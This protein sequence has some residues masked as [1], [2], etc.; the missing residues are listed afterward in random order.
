MRS[1]PAGRARHP[2]DKV[3]KDNWGEA[4]DQMKRGVREQEENLSGDRQEVIMGD[5][6]GGRRK[7]KALHLLLTRT[8]KESGILQAPC[9]AESQL[10]KSSLQ[11]T[12]STALASLS[13]QS[14]LKYADYF[15]C[16]WSTESR[17]YHWLF[18]MAA[19]R[20][21]SRDPHSS[22]YFEIQNYAVWSDRL[23]ILFW[24]WFATVDI[25]EEWT[26]WLQN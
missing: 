7:R 6:R 20:D 26:W 14:S 19:H 15:T 12:R 3:E 11:R 22:I 4:G 8:I 18:R 17:L 16:W 24:W 13:E 5:S 25:W 1:R 21:G 2:R 23:H 10:R 9:R